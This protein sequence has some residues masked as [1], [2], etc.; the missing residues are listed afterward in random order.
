MQGY[1][2]PFDLPAP[3][4][5]EFTS[6]AYLGR[7]EAVLGGRVVGREKSRNQH[8]YSRSLVKIVTT[9]AILDRVTSMLGDDVLLWVAHIL[10]R[11]PGSGGQKWHTDAINQ[12]IRGIHVSIALTEMTQRNGCL[13]LI[14][15]SHLYRASL[16][17][18]EE[19]MGLDRNDIGAVLALADDAAPWNAP[20]SVVHMEVQPGQ[21]FF[22]WGGLWH[23]VGVNATD[24]SRIACVA[25]YLRPDFRCCDHGFRDDRIDSGELQP[26]L[27]VHGTDRFGLNDI[28]PHPTGDIFASNPA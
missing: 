10:A 11:E 4:V 2:G 26:C 22:T 20:H 21:F 8:L 3:V 19:S 15:G 12:Y 6:G 23:G 27:L 9:E 17:A 5:E 25:R 13:S 14:P 24:K 16:W 7:V 18:H 28:R 1:L